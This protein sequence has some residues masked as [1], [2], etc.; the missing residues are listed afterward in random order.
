[1]SLIFGSVLKGNKRAEETR[2]RTTETEVGTIQSQG[3]ECQHP[4]E[5]GEGK[6]RALPES[7]KREHSPAKHLDSVPHAGPAQGERK[8]L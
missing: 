7:L 3:K 2:H 1:M 8:F 5:A 4:L 6:A